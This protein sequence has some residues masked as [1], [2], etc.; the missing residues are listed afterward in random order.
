MIEQGLVVRR[1]VEGDAR[2]ISWAKD[3]RYCRSAFHNILCSD[4]SASVREPDSWVVFVAEEYG[5]IIGVASAYCDSRA[6][7]L[8]RLLVHPDYRGK[9]LN[10][11][12]VKARV[13]HARDVW[14]SQNVFVTF[15]DR[16]K[17]VKRYSE[18]GF[19]PVDDR[20]YDAVLRLR[21][22]HV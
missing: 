11:L 12:L 6:A 17:G 2:R 15:S 10:D 14:H 3:S 16:E 1:A 4:I 22:K 21:D 20:N 18:F 7:V 13:D 5:K 8:H 9:G 19:K